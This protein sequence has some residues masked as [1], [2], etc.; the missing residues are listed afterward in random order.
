M[1]NISAYL[2]RTFLKTLGTAAAA[3][4]F[5]TT[6]SLARSPNGKLHHASFG[7]GGMALRDLKAIDDCESVEMVALC[8]VDLDRTAGA[9]KLFP[10]AKV[11]QDWRQ[12]LDKEGKN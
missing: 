11:Y 8:D 7:C 10:N 3:A 2:R 9:R 12:L 6:G 5:V 1:K 4:P